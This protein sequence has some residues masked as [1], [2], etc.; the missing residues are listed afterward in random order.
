MRLEFMDRIKND[1]IL[2][3]SIFTSEGNI[4]LRAGVKLSR[5]YINKL[6]QLGV[7]YVYVEDSMLDDVA[8][9]DE[10]LFRLKRLTLKSMSKISKNLY[11]YNKR[12]VNEALKISEELISYIIEM[13]DVNN[14]LYDIHTYDNYTFIHSLDTGVMATFMGIY[15]GKFNEYQIKQL[16]IGALLHDIGKIKINSN[17]INKKG[18]L[19]EGEFKE[20]QKHPA[21]GEQLLLKNP[22]IS[23]EAIKIVSE[24]HEKVD[25]K[26]YPKGLTDNRISLFGKIVSICDVYSAVNANRCYRKRMKPNDAYELI[27][28]GS[29]SSFDLKMVDIFKKSFAIYPLGCCVKLSDGNEGYVIRQNEGFPNRPIVRVLYDNVTKEKIQPYELDLMRELNLVIEDLVI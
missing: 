12:G 20:I 9:E 27:L 10:E 8:E 17:I 4:L 6:G 22:R 14:N 19:T 1:E 29:G 28:A 7:N 26:G 5:N 16:G 18:R 23:E 21:Y 15:S 13:R 24:H 3:K 2:G 11:N 25:G